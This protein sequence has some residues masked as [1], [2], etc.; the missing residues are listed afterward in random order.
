MSERKCAYSYREQDVIVFQCEY[1]RLEGDV[2]CE[3]HTRDI[4]KKK[5]EFGEALELL[6]EQ[7]ESESAKHSLEFIGYV[8]PKVTFKNRVFKKHV[9]LRNATFAGDADFEKCVFESGVVCR[10]THFQKLA[11]F[12]GAVFK[13]NAT[14]VNTGFQQLVLIGGTAEKKIAF[15]GCKFHGSATFASRSFKGNF[16]LQSSM[17]IKDADFHDCQFHERFDLT[18][19]EFKE[20]A[21]FVGASFHD[22]IRLE[23]SRFKLLKGIQG[24]RLNFDA[25]V[26]HAPNFQK[27]HTFYGYSFR[28]AFL[29]S[30]DFSKKNLAGCD[31][32]GAVLRSLNV[33]NSLLDAKTCELTKYIYTDYL[34]REDKEDDH[35]VIRYLPAEESRVPAKGDFG[36][37]KNLGFTLKEYLREREKWEFLLDLPDDVRTGILNY[38]NFFRDYLKA[39][40]NVSVDIGA[41]AEGDK[42]KITILAQNHADMRAVDSAFK[43][44]ILNLFEPFDRMK[45]AFRNEKLE[46]YR[47]AIF[48]LNYQ[49]E[50]ETVRTRLKYNLSSPADLERTS[51]TLVSMLRTELAEKGQ[52]LNQSFRMLE[53]L[54]KGR[55]QLQSVS[56]ST[57]I[58]VNQQTTVSVDN[59]LEISIE[60]S[61]LLDELELIKDKGRVIECLFEEVE[62]IK[63][64]LKDTHNVHSA[65]SRIQKVIKSLGSIADYAVKNGEKIIKIGEALSKL[66]LGA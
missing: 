20:R 15:N 52:L 32:T 19:S 64:E 11:F 46:E 65:K 26:L 35:T 45:T 37:A 3:F 63:K 7:A 2:Y 5:P 43:H 34:V 25:T 22:E 14:F 42:T 28:N 66:V 38:V 36:D 23:K 6:I 31:F 55:P 48:L 1:N 9:D 21:I 51:E 60:L 39:T 41:A 16:L 56:I 4:R 17:F 57:P 61:R 29:I 53:E 50:L 54:T 27:T 40:E 10:S 62:S 30:C 49:N 12:Q 33:D 58:T 59:Q 8:F 18:D 24:T 47:K 44:Y 13:A